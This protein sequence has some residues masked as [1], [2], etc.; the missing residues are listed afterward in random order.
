VKRV[1]Q[2]YRRLLYKD[3]LPAWE[4]RQLSKATEFALADPAMRELRSLR[5]MEWRQHQKA[6]LGKRSYDQR[7]AFYYVAEGLREKKK[8][9]VLKNIQGIRREPKIA[10]AIR[11]LRIQR[12]TPAGTEGRYTILR[13]AGFFPWEARILANMKDI[14]PGLRRHTFLS[15][16]WQ[17]MVKNHKAYMVKMLV[18][19]E[20][21]LRKEMGIASFNLLS[22]AQKKRRAQQILDAMLRKAYALGR[23]SPFDWLKREYRPKTKPRTYQSTQRKRSKS[24][25]DRLLPT[26]K[27]REQSTMFFD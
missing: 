3:H 10:R 20:A 16:P 2:R 12:E 14:D 17:A 27:Q 24:K 15:K 5:R 22:N 9:Q 26:K 21:R 23:Y 25:T 6:G 18:K 11:M 19:A 8:Y 7:V 1:E 4:A 13:K